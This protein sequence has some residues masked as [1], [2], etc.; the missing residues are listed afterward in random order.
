MNIVLIGPMYPLR[1]GIAHASALLSS[2]LAHRH[3]VTL[4]SFKRQYPSF[5]FPGTSQYEDEGEGIPVPC[6]HSIDSINPFTWWK[7]GRRVRALAP[8]LVIFRYW[9]PFFAPCYTVIG[10]YAHRNPKTRILF[11]CDNII[12]H[13]RRPGD[14]ILTRLAFSQADYAIVQSN[15]VEQELHRITQHIP[16][17][18]V[19]HPVYESFG[20][21]IS[22]TEARRKLGIEDEH[23]ILFFGFI[24]PYKGLRV[25][26][27][28]MPIVLSSM[29]LRLLIA[30]EFYKG[31]EEYRA[32]ISSLSLENAVT[33]HSSY[34]AHSEVPVFFSA[35]DAVVLPY[36]SATQS[37]IVQ[38]AYNFDKP[39][40]TTHVGGLSE[41]VQHGKTGYIVPPQDP[42]ALAQAILKFYQENNEPSFVENVRIEKQKYSW[43][44]MVNAIEQLVQHPSS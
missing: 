25:L 13:D 16:Y 22:K 30:G 27:Q 20:K 37:G 23:V 11:L 36:N 39:V 9:M 8:D 40:I 44:T 19:P 1:G 10:W 41:V 14:I 17:R 18:H 4:F 15:A 29:K 2:Y 34:I 3:T 28:A 35:A 32:L 43:D 12:P 24:R 31:E 21:P 7:V 33:V 5:L 38:I 42:I 6:E 26:L